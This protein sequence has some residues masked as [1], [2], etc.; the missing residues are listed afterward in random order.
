M[1][2]PALRLRDVDYTREAKL[3]GVPALCV[4]G[5]QDGSTPPDLVLEM[6]KLIPA[7]NYEVIAGAGTSAVRRT[8]GSARCGNARLHFRLVGRRRQSMN[9]RKAGCG[10]CTFGI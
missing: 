3:I 7:A 6:A 8:T 2:V 1:P 5:D 9:M 10:R 4:V